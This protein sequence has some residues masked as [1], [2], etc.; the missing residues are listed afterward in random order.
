[1]LID[2]PRASSDLRQRLPSFGTKGR[3]TPPLEVVCKVGRGGEKCVNQ[4][5]L[6]IVGKTSNG[7]VRPSVGMLG[8]RGRCFKFRN[9]FLFK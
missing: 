5:T 2:S 7:G 4:L 3:A 1:M 6:L 8:V 9:T